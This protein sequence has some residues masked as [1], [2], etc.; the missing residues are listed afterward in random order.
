MCLLSQAFLL[1][2]LHFPRNCRE[3]GEATFP[4]FL[5]SVAVVSSSQGFFQV[6]RNVNVLLSS[7]QNANTFKSISAQL[8]ECIRR[9]ELT[10]ATIPNNVCTRLNLFLFTWAYV[11]LYSINS[12][13]F[14]CFSFNE[15]Q[16]NVKRRKH[17]ESLAESC[18]L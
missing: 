15:S 17:D 1:K 18:H 12:I 16:V 9:L 13:Q 11:Y 5:P 14:N 10:M 7:S 8:N 3:V 6:L 2:F 4:A